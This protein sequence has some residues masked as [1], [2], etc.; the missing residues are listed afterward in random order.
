MSISLINVENEERVDDVLVMSLA[1]KAAPT[2]EEHSIITDHR[3]KP[4]GSYQSLYSNNEQRR[5][6]RDSTRVSIDSVGRGTV[7]GATVTC[8]NVG[9]TVKISSNRLVPR[10]RKEKVVL[11]DICTKLH[12]GMNAILGP[13]GSGKSSLLDIIADRKQRSGLSGHVLV[14]GHPLPANWK[15]MTGYVV[16]DDVVMGT[17]SVEENLMF[18][19]QLRLP[20]HL[21]KEEKQLRVTRVIDELGLHDCRNTR[22]GTEFIRGIS[23]GERKRTNIGME[24]IISPTVLFLDEPTTGLDANTANTVMLILANLAK[25][26][27]TII[28]SIHQPRYSI[29][30]L[31]DD[32]TLLAKGEVAYHGPTSSALAYFEA[33]GYIC[34]LHNNPPDFFLD[35]LNGDAARV[36]ERHPGKREELDRIYSQFNEY[37]AT[38]DHVVTTK[39][40]YETTFLT[41]L[42]LVAK[43]TALNLVRNPMTSYFQLATMMIFAIAVGMLFFQV[44][45][46]TT[47]GIQN[48]TGAFF[49]MVM[50]VMFGNL[51]TVE[52]FLNERHIFI[53]ETISGFYRVSAYF[54]AKL[55]CDILPMRI[56]PTTLFATITYWMVGFQSDAGKFFFYMLALLTTTVAASSLAFLMSASVGVFALAS[57]GVALTFVFSMVFSGLLVNLDTMAGWLSWI[58]FFSIFRYGMNALQVNELADLLLCDTVENALNRAQCADLLGVADDAG[59]GNATMTTPSAMV[60]TLGN[61]YLKKQGIAYE[62][63][64]DLWQNIA[65]LALITLV[66]LCLAYVQL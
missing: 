2:Q 64:W 30:R 66:L 9:Y 13:T 51:S 44:E 1:G 46:D 28:F 58:Q 17:L 34:D 35:V 57:M 56:V 52:L 54:L 12:P 19:A 8:H 10:K 42:R 62:T 49:F 29:Y 21:S 37:V 40:K 32:M 4:T 14:N 20:A 47:S 65:A 3:G 36:S 18:S 53:H 60:C 22:I 63:S 16:Q 6:D 15:L 11:K 7:A 26:G 39:G 41:Q 27:R 43:R 33:L 25:K 31:F 45:S 50:N 55:F 48:R 23:G 61:V 24:L 5:L 59:G 38:G